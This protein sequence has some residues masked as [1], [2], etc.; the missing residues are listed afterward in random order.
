MQR[1]VMSASNSENERDVFELV[2]HRSP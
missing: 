2:A 1:R